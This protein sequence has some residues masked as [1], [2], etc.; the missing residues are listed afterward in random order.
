ME[1][2]V[3]SKE[4]IFNLMTLARSFYA[5][6]VN[7]PSIDR[8]LIKRINNDCFILH[9]CF[10]NYEKKAVSKEAEDSY[11]FLL[12]VLMD[13]GYMSK[14]SSNSTDEKQKIDYIEEIVD[15][16]LKDYGDDKNNVVVQNVIKQLEIFRN[17]CSTELQKD[18]AKRLMSYY[19][20]NY[21]GNFDDVEN[22]YKQW[23]K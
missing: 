15:I 16:F 23:R 10:I 14:T 11:Y 4:E 18:N 1:K 2:E 12:K 20:E 5:K 7:N 3:L 13:N 8:N 21:Y 9:N 17:P 22:K 19:I 6:N